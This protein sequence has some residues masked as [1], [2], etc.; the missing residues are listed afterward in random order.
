MKLIKQ[1]RSDWREPADPSVRV[2]DHK[3]VFH[4]AAGEVDSEWIRRHWNM[5]SRANA[6]EYG[7]IAAGHLLVHFGWA[8][9]SNTGSGSV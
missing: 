6:T 2:R 7:G 4:K 3:L 5:S 1:A 8:R 9:A